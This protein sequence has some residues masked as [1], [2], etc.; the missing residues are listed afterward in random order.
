MSGHAKRRDPSPTFKAG[1]QVSWNT[2]QGTT[3]GKVK[4]KLTEPTDIKRHHVAASADN[5]Q[6][7]VVADDSGA[8]AAHKPAA[9]T[10]R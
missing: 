5:P 6:Y 9:L 4:R 3:H 8:E 1:D 2:P 10:K 7:L